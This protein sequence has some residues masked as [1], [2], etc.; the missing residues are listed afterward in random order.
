MTF[1][2]GEINCYVVVWRLW[3]SIQKL[4]FEKKKGRKEREVMGVTIFVRSPLP[5]RIMGHF[6]EG[7]NT[8]SLPLG[9][10]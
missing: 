3:S 4:A 8:S 7:L 6:Q 10:V 5:R 2:H 9:T 1:P